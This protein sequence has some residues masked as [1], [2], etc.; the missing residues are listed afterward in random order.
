MLQ[1]ENSEM[2]KNHQSLLAAYFSVF[3]ALPLPLL[4]LLLLDILVGLP[5]CF[6]SSLFTRDRRPE[7]TPNREEIK[8]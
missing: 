4:L 5:C 8:I 7:P 2:K 6:G 3:L 1:K